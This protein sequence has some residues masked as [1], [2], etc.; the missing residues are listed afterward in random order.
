MLDSLPEWLWRILEEL[1]AV[2]ELDAR[3]EVQQTVVDGVTAGLWMNGVNR[4]GV[5]R[6]VKNQRSEGGLRGQGYRYVFEFRSHT[7]MMD[8][9]WCFASSARE[10]GPWWR[11]TL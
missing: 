10:S 3:A 9:S 7:L 11:H 8:T 5:F 1:G 2:L 6:H 4:R